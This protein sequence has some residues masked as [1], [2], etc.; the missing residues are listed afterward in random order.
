MWVGGVVG[1]GEEEG[2]GEVNGEV[3]GWMGGVG[4][5]GE[6]GVVNVEGGIGIVEWE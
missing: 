1:V 2:V 3:L 5:G 6:R 4:E